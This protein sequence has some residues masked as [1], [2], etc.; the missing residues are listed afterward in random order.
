MA[1]KFK[2]LL[3]EKAQ[4]DLDEIVSHIAIELSNPKAFLLKCK[5]QSRE[6]ACSLKASN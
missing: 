6:Y 3:T 1:Y 4:V 2:Y 5:N